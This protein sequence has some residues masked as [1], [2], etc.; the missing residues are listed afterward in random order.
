MPTYLE[1]LTL[2]LANGIGELPEALRHRHASFLRA[3]QRA[4]GGFPGREGDSDLYY[5]GF[6]LRSLAILGELH[7]K[8]ARD[9]A[10]FLRTRLTGRESIV[11]F[12]SLIYSAQLL[13][14]LCDLD[15][16]ADVA[17][18][19]PLAVI[20]SLESLRRD[21]GGYAKGPDGTA[22]STYHTF[23]VLLCL[24]MVEADV[25]QPDQVVEFL[26]SQKM[27]DGGF[28][29]IR[30]SR[31]ASTNPTAAAIGALRILN[32]LT[33]E[34]TVHAADF[35]LEMQTDE[36]GFRANSRIPIADLL[37]TFTS[38][39]TLIDLEAVDRVAP[40]VVEKFVASLEQDAGGF[41]GASWDEVCDVEYTFYGL[42]TQGLLQTCRS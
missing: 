13:R 35:L 7:G 34:T 3:R 28:R 38:L 29:E 20:R 41:L 31:R 14:S 32:A 12:Y 8:V 36:G 17:V 37:S 27:P 40:V 16:M 33:A 6:A 19:W 18:D 22:S 39:V 1:Q 5:T 11:D 2:R 10:D 23:L 4:D 24:E 21:D 26:N 9:A 15:V 30:V 25:P 42:G